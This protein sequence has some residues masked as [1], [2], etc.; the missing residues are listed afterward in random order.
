MKLIINKVSY[1]M[2]S[3]ND[4]SFCYYLIRENQLKFLKSLKNC[5][6]SGTNLILI[7]YVVK[8]F[9]FECYIFFI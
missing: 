1:L 9:G 3:L 2:K 7:R 5:G 8:K 6:S 4:Y